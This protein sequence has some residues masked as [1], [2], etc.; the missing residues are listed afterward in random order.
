MQSSKDILTHT[1][2]SVTGV[3]IFTKFYDFYRHLTVLITAFPKT[4]RYTLGQRLDQISLDVIELLTSVPYSQNKSETLG[5][6]SRKVDL[7]KVL[8]RLAK[9]TQALTNKNYVE[10]QAILQEIGKMLGGWIKSTKQT[11]L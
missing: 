2:Y 8:L 5:Q 7:L 9:D 11:S 3:P 6:I 1:T 10:L 4:K